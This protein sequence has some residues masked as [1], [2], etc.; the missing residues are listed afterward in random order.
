MHNLT[1]NVNENVNESIQL[2]PP[3]P[4]PK[5]CLSPNEWSCV[6]AVLAMYTERPFTTIIRLFDHDGSDVV[7]KEFQDSRKYRGFSMAEFGRAL[8]KTN[9][10]M[11]V[12][13]APTEFFDNDNQVFNVLASVGTA[14]LFGV[15]DSGVPHVVLYKDKLIYDT[16]GGIRNTI[17]MK[18][19]GIVMLFGTMPNE[20]YII[21]NYPTPVARYSGEVHAVSSED[22]GELCVPAEAAH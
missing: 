1:E 16:N 14:I 18:V 22:S 4:I 3:T 2:I 11:F 7:N 10:H 19:E 20:Q 6:P 21:D 17:D 15:Q 13:F 12:N 5:E 8:H 9:L